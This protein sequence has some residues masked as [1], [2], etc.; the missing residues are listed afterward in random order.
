MST[1]S[2][3]WGAVTGL[4]LALTLSSPPPAL[5]AQGWIE[6]LPGRPIPAGAWAV[7][8]T[9]SEVRVTVEGRVARVELDRVVP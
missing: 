6:P 7:E 2:R 4:T 5:S 8:K 9:R 1:L 3:P